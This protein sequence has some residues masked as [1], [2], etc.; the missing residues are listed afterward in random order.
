PCT[1]DGRTPPCAPAVAAA[2]IRRVVIGTADPNPR[3]NGA[4]IRFLHDAGI[5]VEAGVL[6]L[7]CRRMVEAFAKHVLTG[8]AFVTGK[9]AATLDG[10]A[11]AVDGS[12]KWITGPTARRDAHRLR[13]SVDAVLVGVGTVLKDDPR[14]TVRL[15]GFKGR[16][17]LRVVLDSSGRT[18]LQSSVL[19]AEAPTLVA[20]T[21]KAPEDAVAALRAH[22]AEV[23]RA[24]ARDGRIDLAATLDFLGGRDVMEVM[25]EGGP[26]VLGD[27]VE[28]GLV[29]RYVFY[30]APKLLGSS[31][32]P[33]IAGFVTP[34]IAEARELVV[35]SVRHA[36]ADLRVEAY[37]RP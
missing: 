2:G 12:S 29:D 27:A 30:L 34:T 37:P 1:V 18:P 17:P 20:V 16:Q 26:A 11:A 9:I 33:A 24:P 35:H 25:I 23:W 32:L 5:D 3:V 14:L 31:G 36:G 10:R 28:H 21:D 13:G 6:E 19:N 7:D 15:R 4:G 8:R 22:G